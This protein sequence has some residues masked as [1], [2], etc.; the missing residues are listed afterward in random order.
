MVLTLLFLAS[1]CEPN[2]LPGLDT[3]ALTMRSRYQNFGL[4]FGFVLV[5]VSFLP[6]DAMLARN[7]LSSC[8]RPSVC[9]SRGGARNLWLGGPKFR[10]LGPVSNAGGVGKNWRL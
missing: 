7:M 6:R 10:G 8:V 3:E 4:G 9:R 5:S 2:I 1:A